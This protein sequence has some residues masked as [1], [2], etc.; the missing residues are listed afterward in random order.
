[1]L[2]SNLKFPSREV[3]EF[4]CRIQDPKR[5]GGGGLEVFRAA[6]RTVRRATLKCVKAKGPFEKAELQEKSC[7]W[8]NSS[9][10]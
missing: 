1:M 10:Y 9:G 2:A 7:I 8:T 3:R 6:R 5:G 4:E